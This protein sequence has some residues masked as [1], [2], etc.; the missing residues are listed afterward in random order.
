MVAVLLRVVVPLF[1]LTRFPEHPVATAG[2]V[3][4]NELV[5]FEAYGVLQES[6]VE[7]VSTVRFGSAAAAPKAVLAVLAE[8]TPISPSTFPAL[9][10]DMVSEN[11][12]AF[13]ELFSRFSVV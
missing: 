5:E 3:S 10:F 9:G 7:V 1:S 4:V 8:E 13:A 11:P 12:A 6:V 2:I